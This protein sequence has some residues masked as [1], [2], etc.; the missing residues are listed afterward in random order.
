MSEAEN[1]NPVR[2]WRTD[3]KLSLV[4]ACELFPK[5]GYP[6]PSIAKLSRIE[7]GQPI[8]KEMVPALEA[9]TGTPARELLPEF[10]KLLG[11]S[12]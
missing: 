11:I 10:A 7:R 4:D 1:T 2:K 6:K 12:Q 9:I 3:H 5:H 8:P